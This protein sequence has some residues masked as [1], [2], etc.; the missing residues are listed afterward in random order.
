MD[1]VKPELQDMGTLVEL[2][3]AGGTVGFEDGGGKHIDVN[4]VGAVGV[5]IVLLP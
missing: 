1:Y 5:S 2:T 3:E 4:V